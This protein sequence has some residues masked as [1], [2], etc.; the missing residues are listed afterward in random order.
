MF[1]CNLGEA[2]KCYKC[3]SYSDLN[4]AHDDKLK[5]SSMANTVNCD[6]A[7]RPSYALSGPLVT[8][9]A[10]MNI[11]DAAGVVIKRDCHW[12]SYNQPQPNVCSAGINVEIDNCKICDSDYCNSATSLAGGITS[13][14]ALIVAV[15]A[16]C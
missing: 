3:S 16:L 11:K 5:S 2:I 12:E 15:R 13:L 6:E 7:R 1:F 9:C 14:V 8:K 4:C 10:T